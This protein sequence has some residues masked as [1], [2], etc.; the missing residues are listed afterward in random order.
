V[1]LLTPGDLRLSTAAPR[2]FDGFV[3]QRVTVNGLSTHVRS[4][5]R[6]DGTPVVLLHGLAVSHRYLMPTARALAERHPVHV[7]DLPGFGL[8]AKPSAVYGPDAHARHVADLLESTVGAPV[9]LVGHSFGAE[10]AARLAALRPDLVCALVLA[11]PTSDPSA[12]SY[13]GLV[14]RWFVDLVTED[15][16]QAALLA[17]DLRDAGPRRVLGSLRASV[18]NRIEVDLAVTAMPV[19]FLRG[20]RDTV[21]PLDWLYRAAAFCGGSTEVAE[22]PGAGHN[23]L[24]TAAVESARLISGFVGLVRHGPSGGTNG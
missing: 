20:S 8:S 11:G 16:R 14:G 10:V 3:S 4:A 22:L 17:R 6:V 7:P 12:R 21:A 24:T 5:E 19:L 18:H 9:C 1:R 2:P 13:R 15:P 23:A